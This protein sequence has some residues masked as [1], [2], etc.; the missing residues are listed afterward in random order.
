MEG[1]FKSRIDGAN[2]FYEKCGKGP[3]IVL[4]DGVF[5]DGHIWR[6]FTPAFKDYHTV[7][8]W[9]Y[10]GH[11]RSTV[12]PSG[13][14]VGP[15]R[16]AD[17]AVA[18]AEHL[19]CHRA[20]YM[21]HSLGVQVALEAWKRNRGAVAGLVLTCGSP[22]R[23]AETFHDSRTLS[24]LLPLLDAASRLVPHTVASLWRRLP[25]KALMLGAMATREVNSRLIRASD[26]LEYF[27]RLSHMDF[28]FG[29]RMV[30]GAGRHDAT[31][32]L[33]EIDVPVLVVGGQEDRF[34][35]PSRSLLL[36]E[37]V[38]SAEFLLVPGATHSLPIE[39]PELFN[40]RVKR[41]LEARI[42]PTSTTDGVPEDRK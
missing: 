37:R 29:V 13:S 2:L 8:H 10:P 20:L 11:G 31:P 28:G 41:F 21:G 24:Y 34:T 19:D 1:F 33:G 35:P 26:L 25:T 3:P 14:P 4:C 5:C 32:Y 30:E 38:P 22:G 15:E 23:L 17:D 42:L 9:H 36:A 7:I 18:V 6:Y 12:P 16:L 27:T 39:M 40:L